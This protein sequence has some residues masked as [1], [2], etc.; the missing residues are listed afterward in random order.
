MQIFFS[1][2]FVIYVIYQFFTPLQ[3]ADSKN[4]DI[5]VQKNEY[6]KRFKW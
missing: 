5:E 6:L 2:F 4:Q 1:Y 3:A